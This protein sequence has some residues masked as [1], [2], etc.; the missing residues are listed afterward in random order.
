MSIYTLNGIMSHQVHL[1]KYDTVE[2]VARR[3]K[4]NETTCAVLCVYPPPDTDVN[5]FLT[6]YDTCMFI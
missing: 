2:V 5:T 4:L 1:P 6:K 3:V